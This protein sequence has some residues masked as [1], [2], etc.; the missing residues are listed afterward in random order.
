MVEQILNTS[1]APADLWLCALKY[2][3]FFINHTTLKCLGWQT[4]TAEWL[5]RYK[6]NITVLLPFYFYELVYYQELN[7][8]SLKTP[9][10]CLGR[11]V[12]IS[13]TISNAIITFKILMVN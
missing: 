11:F 3:C 4:P 10:E 13:E 12:G 6:P 2:T 9:N 8:S 1:D 5:L 7:K